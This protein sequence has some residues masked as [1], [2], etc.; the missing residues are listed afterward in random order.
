MSPLAP[1]HP[2]P[3]PI[4]RS[5]DP[6]FTARLIRLTK[7]SA[8]ALGSI[9]LLWRSGPAANGDTIA[10]HPAVGAALLAGWLL[11]P[12]IL[13]LSL[14]RPARRPSLLLPSTLVGVALLAVS[15]T[16]PPDPLAAL[17]WR[18][19]TAGIWLG[20][21]LGAWLWFGWLPLPVP[22][23]LRDPFSPQRWALIALH[24]AL[25]L[26]GLL[27]IGLAFATPRVS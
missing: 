8:V 4:E 24:V 17:G 23:A 22:T 5:T 18:L 2:R 19:L 11:M 25:I 16:P 20:G 6:R 13:L 26:V 14:R 12:T 7:T 10:A 1:F 3:T 27:L 21:F 15:L 9:W